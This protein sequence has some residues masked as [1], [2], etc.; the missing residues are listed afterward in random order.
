M[1]EMKIHEF[2]DAVDHILL[3]ILDERDDL[4]EWVDNIMHDEARTWARC[5][6]KRFRVHRHT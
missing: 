5:N 2:H 3:V 1:N 6:I 4:H